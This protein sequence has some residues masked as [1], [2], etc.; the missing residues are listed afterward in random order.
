M[1]AAD[2]LA[3]VCIP[4]ISPRERRTRLMAGAIQLAVALV[5]LAVL[6]VTGVDRWWRLVLLPVFWGAGSGYFQSRDKT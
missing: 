4:N 6:V 1:A 3:A 2:A 5:I